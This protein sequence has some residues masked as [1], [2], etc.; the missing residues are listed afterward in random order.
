MIKHIFSISIVC[1][2]LLTYCAQGRHVNDFRFATWNSRG[3]RWADVAS[4]MIEGNLDVLTVQESGAL[5]DSATADPNRIVPTHYIGVPPDNYG[6]FVEEFQWFTNGGT[7][8]IF[9]YD[10]RSRAEEVNSR[11]DPSRAF[12]MAIITREQPSLL[13]LMP[14]IYPNKT[15]MPP[16]DPD[17]F[18]NRP[19]IGVQLGDAAFF[20]L[21]AAPT[22]TD[23]EAVAVIEIIQDYMHDHFSALTWAVTG[24]FNRAPQ[25]VT[26]PRRT[27]TDLLSSGEKTH[28]SAGHGRSAE[29]DYGYW[30]GPT[31][32][33]RVPFGNIMLLSEH[34]RATGRHYAGCRSDHL[35][36]VFF[37]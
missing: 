2:F 23:N 26:P 32:R 17:Y 21:H 20:N 13:F 36:V 9:Y 6:L 4:F 3:A 5:P 25:T 1:L 19:I 18:I 10:R 16:S 22:N 28:P 37:Q 29:L 35:P 33:R 27:F 11:R 14:M 34:L 8:H 12:N 15:Q 30:G 31:G 7:F 24:D